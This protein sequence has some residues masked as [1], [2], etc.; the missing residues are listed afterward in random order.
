MAGRGEIACHRCGEFKRKD[1][2]IFVSGDIEYH[3]IERKNATP[4]CKHCRA[5]LVYK[6]RQLEEMALLAD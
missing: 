1:K 3:G 5:V 2:L 4:L 6:L